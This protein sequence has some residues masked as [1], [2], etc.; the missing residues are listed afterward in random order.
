MAAAHLRHTPRDMTNNFEL[1]KTNSACQHGDRWQQAGRGE[2]GEGGWRTSPAGRALSTKLSHLH[3]SRRS[4]VVLATRRRRRRRVANRDGCIPAAAAAVV[5]VVVA[6]PRPSPTTRHRCSRRHRTTLSH[7]GLRR[8]FRR[9]EAHHRQRIT[10]RAH[11]QTEQQHQLQIYDEH[12]SL[13][14]KER[15]NGN[16]WSDQPA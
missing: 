13:L 2:G 6:G 3:L 9:I 15:S 14:S 10:I 7:S 4:S 16:R 11:I 12:K 8:L 1:T 5:V